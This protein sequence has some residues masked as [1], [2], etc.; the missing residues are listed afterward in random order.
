MSDGVG[1]GDNIGVNKMVWEMYGGIRKWRPVE[2]EM[3]KRW[4]G[5]LS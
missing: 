1:D 3:G 2:W 4:N 5:R